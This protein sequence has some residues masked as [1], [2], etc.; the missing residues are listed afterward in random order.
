[1]KFKNKLWEELIA[2]FL[3]YDMDCIENKV[4]NNFSIPRE[5]VYRAVA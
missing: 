2:S 5:R 3:W 4:S 1:M